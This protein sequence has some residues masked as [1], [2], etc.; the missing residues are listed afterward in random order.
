MTV[1]YAIEPSQ[2]CSA[3]ACNS[4]S[5][6]VHFCRNIF[7]YSF[8]YTT[9]VNSTNYL[10]ATGLCRYYK[11]GE[12]TVKA[13]DN[14]SF[15][16]NRGD[17]LALVGSSGSGKTTLLNL[18]AGLDT[19]TSGTVDFNGSILSAMSRRK[20]SEYR[21]HKIGM[22]FQSFNLISH[23][24]AL[25]NVETALYFNGTGP[26]ERKR[27]ATETLERLG[28]AERLTHRPADLSGGEQQRV[29]LARAIVKTPDILFAD[30]PTGNLD[31]ENTEQI[32]SLLTSLNKNG[33]TIILVTH[34][35]DMAKRLANRIFRMQ[36]GKI[37]E[38]I[39][40]NPDGD[41]SR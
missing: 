2:D 9:N 6:P 15:S 17:L 23:Y 1:L 31:Q 37:I 14:V 13:L 38:T 29:A 39:S 24:S 27:L 26:A 32:A 35:P 18:L 28:L 10:N 21:A 3:Y 5:H 20:L 19:P 41:N 30:E 34:N 40:Q 16:I 11:R 12:H 4:A 8:T 33:L 36:Y 22:V 25:Q 7:L